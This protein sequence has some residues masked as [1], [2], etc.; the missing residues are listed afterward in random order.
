MKRTLTPAVLL[1]VVWL[2]WSGQNKPLLLTLG[3]VSV[4]L[5]LA[6][7]S[8]PLSIEAGAPRNPLRERNMLPKVLLQ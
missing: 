8:V 4:A 1:I 5:V 2:L 6:T 7:H 3:L